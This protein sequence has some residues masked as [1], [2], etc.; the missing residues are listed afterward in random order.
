MSVLTKGTALE[1]GTAGAARRKK[2]LNWSLVE[3]SRAGSCWSAPCPV[4]QTQ[5][6]PDTRLCSHACRPG[7]PRQ[8]AYAL[9]ASLA[10]ARL[11]LSRLP[12]SRFI[13]FLLDPVPD[14]L[15]AWCFRALR[16]EVRAQRGGPGPPTTAF[17][18]RLC[19]LSSGLS[20]SLAGHLPQ[21]VPRGPVRGCHSG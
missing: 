21:K 17:S 18:T 20:L 15:R 9:A 2:V 6:A 1:R 10:S 8:T 16:S 4:R 7:A 12:W 5:F 13:R 3:F 19:P 11:V 14:F